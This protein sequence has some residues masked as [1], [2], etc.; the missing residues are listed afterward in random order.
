MWTIVSISLC[1]RREVLKGLIIFGVTSAVIATPVVAIDSVVQGTQQ[2]LL[3]NGSFEM[4]GFGRTMTG[5][6]VTELPEVDP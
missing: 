4:N 3:Q 6:T 2:N 1:S 5:W